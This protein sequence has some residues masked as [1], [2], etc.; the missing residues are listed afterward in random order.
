[1]GDGFKYSAQI[2][3]VELV[4]LGRV[5]AVAILARD[6]FSYAVETRC[7]RIV[8]I[9]NHPSGNLMPSDQDIFVTE[10]MVDAGLLLNITIEDHLIISEVD[11]RSFG[12]E[13]KVLYSERKKKKRKRPLIYDFTDF[14][15]IGKKGGKLDR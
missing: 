2:E 5:N 3:Y 15:G 10:K 9:H 14:P 6:V 12:D 8:L 4:A 11:Y 7:A 1:M 13:I